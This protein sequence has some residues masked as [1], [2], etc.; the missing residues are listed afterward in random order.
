MFQLPTDRPLRFV[1]LSF[2]ANVAAWFI[3]ITLWESERIS[4][5]QVF[6]LIAPF[7]AASAVITFRM[8][9]WGRR[10]SRWIGIGYIGWAC[11]ALLMGAAR[12]PAGWPL[13]AASVAA[14]IAGAA[15]M[16]R[17]YSLANPRRRA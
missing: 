17:G 12:L 10:A 16:A 9:P 6:A 5:E 8:A 2:A 14:W 3:L 13:V 4:F 7:L 1:K 11:G 15:V